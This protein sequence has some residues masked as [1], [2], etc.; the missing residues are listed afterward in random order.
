MAVVA[1][2]MWKQ[3]LLKVF[4][5]T[6][7]AQNV[8]KAKV[9][10]KVEGQCTEAMKSSITRHVHFPAVDAARDGFA[11]LT[12]IEEL[13]MGIEGQHNTAVVISKAKDQLSKLRQGPKT[14]LEYFEI[15]KSKVVLMACI[16]GALVE[17][18]VAAEIAI[19]NGRV[20]PN[21]ADN[22]Q[23]QDDKSVAVSF[24]MHLAY[25]KY[26]VELHNLMLDRDDQYPLLDSGSC[27]QDHAS[28]WT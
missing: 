24:I 26:I 22:R 27:L 14:L 6:L 3:D 28:S 10:L 7:Q 1:V 9:F 16:G 5:N 8:F 17:P 15:Y 18:G 11:L 20:L 25:P 13:S 4:N 21:A 19:A 12:I 23:A 2:H